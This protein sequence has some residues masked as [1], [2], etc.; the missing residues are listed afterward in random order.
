MPVGRGG[1]SPVP[2]RRPDRDAQFDSI[3]TL[4]AGFLAA[5]DPVINIDTKEPEPA[6]SFRLALSV[7]SNRHC[8]THRHRG[9][10]R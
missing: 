2:R 5:G 3:N 1:P 10:D 8:R 4:A 9:C 7:P 6:L